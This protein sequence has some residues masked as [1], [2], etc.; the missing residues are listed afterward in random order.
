MREHADGWA[1][2]RRDLR[3]AKWLTLLC[4]GLISGVVAML[5]T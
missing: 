2:V 3:I 5:F 1:Q 4:V